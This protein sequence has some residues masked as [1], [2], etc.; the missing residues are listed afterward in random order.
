MSCN[1]YS[2]GPPDAASW[3]D[4]A[5]ARRRGVAKHAGTT[6]SADWHSI[7]DRALLKTGVACEKALSRTC[8][9]QSEHWQAVKGEM[10]VVF[11]GQ[12]R[13]EQKQ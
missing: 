6:R 8:G 4:C 3:A 13:H 7:R 10:L 2:E 11:F 5:R 9:I 1:N 12:L